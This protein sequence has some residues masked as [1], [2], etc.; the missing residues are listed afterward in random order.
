[1][2]CPNCKNEVPDGLNR[3]ILCGSDLSVEI[4][5][6]KPVKKTEVLRGKKMR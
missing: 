2:I 5:K 6:K 1:M 3:C 4:V